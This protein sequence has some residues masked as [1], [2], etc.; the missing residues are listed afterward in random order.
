MTAEIAEE[1]KSLGQILYIA[2]MTTENATESVVFFPHWCPRLT[3]RVSSEAGS[4]NVS[5]GW[6]RSTETTA[7]RAV[8]FLVKLSP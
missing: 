5:T 7:D 8:V 4:H 6:G 3:N 2:C 1:N